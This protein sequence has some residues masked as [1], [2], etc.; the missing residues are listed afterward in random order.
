MLVDMANNSGVC[1]I[2]AVAGI[3]RE[4]KI[5]RCYEHVHDGCEKCIQEW[6]NEEFSTENS[7]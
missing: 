7:R 5:M 6:L 3:S 1:P 2:Q 4:N